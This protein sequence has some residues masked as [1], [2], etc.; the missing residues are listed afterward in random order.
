MLPRWFS[1][2]I[3]KERPCIS[4]IHMIPQNGYKYEKNIKIIKTPVITLQ[5]HFIAFILHGVLFK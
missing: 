1:G 3:G 5:T 2:G 4:M